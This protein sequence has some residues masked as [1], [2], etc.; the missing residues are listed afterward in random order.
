LES[1][2]LRGSVGSARLLGLLV[3]FPLLAL[4]VMAVAPLQ[5]AEAQAPSSGVTVNAVNQF[6]EALPGDY[7]TVFQAIQYSPYDSQ[8]E[9]VMATG[10]TSSTFEAA[11]G[12]TY[13]LQVYAY[14]SCTFSHWSDGAV[15]D[16]MTFTAT[17]AALSFTAVY[18]CVGAANIAHSSIFV[19]S[20]YTDGSSLTG[21]YAVLEQDGATVATGFTPMTF[22]TTSGLNYSLIISDSANAVFSQWS[23]GIASNTIFVAANATKTSL[24]ALFCPTTCPSS[25][26]GVGGGSGGAMDSITVTS[27][28]LVTGA[29]MSG[30]YVDLRLNDNHIES[31]Y[32]PVT[33]SGLQQGAKYL[34]VVYGYGDAYFRHFSNGNLQR[35][36]YVTL[37]ATAGQNS[38]SMNA[39]YEVVP[40]AQAASLNIIAQ[41]PNGTQI[42]TASVIDGYP[43]HTPGMYLSVTPPGGTAPYTATFTGGSI[44]PFIFFNHQTYTVAMSL[45]YSNITFS[46]WAD[47]ASTDPTRAFALDGNSTFIAVYNQG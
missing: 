35:Y 16:P 2:R 44:L 43:Q 40:N 11:A 21:V 27:S 33:F 4:T 30:M 29:A 41:F 26:G 13:S 17:G 18:N 1:I 22:T 9:A 20:E 34:V 19:N 7:Y 47:D 8:G 39:L 12:P 24:T 25:A 10:V 46:H 23:N 28:N 38:Y 6:G 42:G 32:T 36:S 37:N 14:G 3:I 45:G 5:G 31:G 15:S